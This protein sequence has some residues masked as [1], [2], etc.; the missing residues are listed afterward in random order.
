MPSPAL[1]L[2][3]ILIFGSDLLG[4]DQLPRRLPPAGIEIPV[5]ISHELF[6]ELAVIEKALRRWKESTP[7]LKSLEPDVAVYLKAVRYA[8]TNG[9]FWNSEETEWAGNLLAVARRRLQ[10]LQNNKNPCT[11]AEGMIYRGFRSTLDDS[12]QPYGL[13]IPAGLDHTRPAP[14]YVF[15]HGR[16]EKMVELQ[17]LEQS[18]N[19]GR[20]EAPGTF[21]L[22]AFGRYCNGYKAAGEVDIREAIAHVCE[23]YMIDPDRIAIT[24]FSMGGAG[25][26][27]LAAHYPDLWMAASPGAGFAETAL[28]NK[29]EPPDYPAW[30]EQSLWGLYDVP[31]YVN[32][33]FNMDVISYS[34]ELDPQV[35]ASEVMAGAYQ[36]YG[37]TLNHIVG[38]NTGHKYHPRSRL[39]ILRQLATTAKRGLNRTPDRVTFQTRTLR[40]DRC[41]WVRVVQIGKH[42]TD[43]RVNAYQKN[44][45]IEIT[46]RNVT[47]LEIGANGGLSLGSTQVR[48]DGEILRLNNNTS[49]TVTLFRNDGTW[50]LDEPVLPQG[51]QKIH[52]LQ[53]PIDDAF[54][55]PFLVVTPSETAAHPRIHEWVQ[56]ELDHFVDRWR[57][58]F[59]GDVRI[60]A[61]VEVTAEDMA[62]Y[63]LV[64][65]GDPISNQVLAEVLPN[66]PVQWTRDSVI[67]GPSEFSADHHVPVLIYPNPVAPDRYVVINSGITFREA[68]DRTNSMQNP[69]LPDWAILDID[70]SPNTVAAGH[71][72]TADF[73]DE[74]WRVSS[75]S[76][77]E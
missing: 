69:K 71:V 53:G 60:K 66:L 52:G 55:E 29:L 40:Y 7:R 61:D 62:R 64:L 19:L 57:R 43:S 70:V 45:S 46:T 21:V 41:R 74:R 1:A 54:L 50:S 9:E 15:L 12:V 63:N 39:E 4:A 67:M 30:Y 28:Y 33:L 73:F 26:W 24:G 56:F 10:M 20:I 51:L 17:F 2:F 36:K 14:L 35:Q 42:W 37:R 77:D 59:R 6:A 8:L 34:G 27:H 47:A 49:T 48:I 13:Y 23:H 22:H 58:L 16:N 76:S 65:W 18:R 31:G 25:V 38:P 32:N 3:V 75:V 72:V 44:G 68:H 11:T 5:K